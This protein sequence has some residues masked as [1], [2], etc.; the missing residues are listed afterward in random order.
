MTSQVFF[1]DS[2]NSVSPHELRELY[3]WTNWGKNRDLEG[4]AKMLRH[5]D[6]C[7]SARLDRRLVGFCRVL[8]DFVYRASLWDIVVHPDCQGRG[9]GTAL[10][11]YALDH[12]LL[13]SVPMTVTYTTQLESFLEKMGFESRQGQMMLLRRPQAGS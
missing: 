13:R 2:S 7:F 10:L 12:P 5:T 1:Y 11:N 9:L 4:I 8:T 6:L 3:G